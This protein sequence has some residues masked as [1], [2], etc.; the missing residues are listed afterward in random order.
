MSYAFHD[1][2][3]IVESYLDDL[4]AHSQQ[5]ED[6]PGHLRDIFLRYRHYN[7]RLNTHKCVLC[8]E[9]GRLLGFVVSKDGIWI[10]PLNISTIINLPS[11]TNILKLQS[12]HGKET[13]ST[14]SCVI[15][16]IKCTVICVSLRRTLHYFGM[17]RPDE[18]LVVLSTL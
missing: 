15:S 1:I 6:H 13:F 2:K 9:T 14:V 16:L 17:T 5:W 7:I 4:P 3:H 11:P 10:D 12:L 8:V 18:P